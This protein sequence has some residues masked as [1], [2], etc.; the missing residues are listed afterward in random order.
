MITI[1]QASF[2]M[3]YMSLRFCVYMYNVVININIIF[4]LCCTH[5][6]YTLFAYYLLTCLS[7]FL[8]PA[9]EKMKLMIFRR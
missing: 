7:I 9:T 5:N 1:L 4:V 2:C 8:C 6:P 3:E